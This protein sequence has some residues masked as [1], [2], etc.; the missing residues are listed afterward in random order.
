VDRNLYGTI[1]TAASVGFI[2][3][4]GLRSPISRALLG[5]GGRYA[6]RSI[7]AKVLNRSPEKTK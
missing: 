3:G 7:S 4:A 1:A 2:L 6:F 5:L